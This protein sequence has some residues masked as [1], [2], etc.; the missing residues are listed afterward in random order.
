MPPVKLTIPPVGVVN[1]R[2][3]GNG[4]GFHHV[5]APFELLR[6]RISPRLPLFTSDDPRF[7]RYQVLDGVDLY[8]PALAGTPREAQPPQRAGTP[9]R[10]AWRTSLP[11]VLMS[12]TWRLRNGQSL[13]AWGRHNL[14]RQFPW[15]VDQQEQGQQT[16]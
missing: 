2:S 4:G 16:G 10:R 13:T 1:W 8:A 15:F 7:A 9:S 11:P 12:L 3:M 5:C 6:A 14:C